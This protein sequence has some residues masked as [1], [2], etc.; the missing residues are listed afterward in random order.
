MDVH[1]T[2]RHVLNQNMLRERKIWRHC[3]KAVD[4]GK[5]KR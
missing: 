5:Q 4:G 2:R 3:G 1:L